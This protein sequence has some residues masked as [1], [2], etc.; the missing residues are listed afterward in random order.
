MLKL[1]AQT[2]ILKYKA[3]FVFI[4]AFHFDKFII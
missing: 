1:L 2:Q 4:K 3:L